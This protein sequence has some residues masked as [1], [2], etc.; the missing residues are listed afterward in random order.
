MT[1]EQMKENLKTIK[2]LEKDLMRDLTNEEKE[3]VMNEGW[4]KF[5]FEHLG[6]T[7]DEYKELKGL[8][9]VI[10][11]FYTQ[12]ESVFEQA[13]RECPF[14]AYFVLKEIMNK[15]DE[16]DMEDSP[17]CDEPAEKY[18][19]PKK[20]MCSTPE[21]KKDPVEGFA[22]FIQN[23]YNSLPKSETKW[24]NKLSEKALKN[25]FDVYNEERND[26]ADC[27]DNS[28][29]GILTDAVKDNVVEDMV[30]RLKDG[31]MVEMTND[32]YMEVADYLC[33]HEDHIFLSNENGQVRLT[34]L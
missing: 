11:A 22:T 15:F 4:E 9:K 30:K 2:L 13:V 18:Y 16:L 33:Q 31:E 32:E 6:F 7:D 34:I 19:D 17:K 8:K 14:E 21:C 20:E 26:K 5:L 27:D 24:F 1:I 28:L 29:G 23:L 25:V 12:D 10:S 3:Y